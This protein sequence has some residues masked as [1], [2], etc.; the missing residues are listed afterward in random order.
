MSNT[1]D[2][3]SIKQWRDL[4]SVKAISYS[5]KF[6]LFTSVMLLLLFSWSGLLAIKNT[7]LSFFNI[8]ALHQ[9]F[10][11]WFIDFLILGLLFSGIIFHNIIKRNANRHK[12]KIN[13]LNERIEINIELANNLKNAQWD[14][15][16]S[17]QDSLSQALLDLSESIRIANKREEEQKWITSGKDQIS[18]LLRNS[19]NLEN[20]SVAVLK[21]IIIYMDGIQGAFYLKQNEVLIRTAMYAYGRRRFEYNEIPEIGRASCRERV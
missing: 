20:L 15:L 5:Q 13:E 9:Q 19:H 11:A 8:I 10:L 21:A 16:H 17:N 14:K 18:E 3:I 4:L 7:P 1:V 12:K 6:L 2:N